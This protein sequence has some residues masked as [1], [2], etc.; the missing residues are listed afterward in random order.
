[1]KKEKDTLLAG[2]LR[3]QL[4]C[5]SNFIFWSCLKWKKEKQEQLWIHKEHYIGLNP[6]SGS[7]YTEY[8]QF[9]IYVYVSVY[10]YIYKI[11]PVLPASEL[12]AMWNSIQIEATLFH[13]SSASACKKNQLH[14]C[15]A[16]VSSKC[17]SLLC[18]SPANQWFQNWN[19]SFCTFWT[20][21]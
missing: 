21:L 16:K 19:K 18:R 3:I 6:N 5:S 14:K 15:A 9:L 1:M 17:C 11:K 10:K 20:V 8:H 7:F 2:N 13:I 4:H 12:L